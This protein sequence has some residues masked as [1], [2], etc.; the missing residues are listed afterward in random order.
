MPEVFVTLHA[1]Y[2]KFDALVFKAEK[3]IRLNP[4]PVPINIG[5]TLAVEENAC[6]PIIY[7]EIDAKYVQVGGVIECITHDTNGSVYLDV[8]SELGALDDIRV[9]YIILASSGWKVKPWDV[10]CSDDLA[11]LA[12]LMKEGSLTAPTP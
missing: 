9:A 8:K 4:S 2:N 10:D 12:D 5:H 7:P 1:T 6:I 11:E 3:K